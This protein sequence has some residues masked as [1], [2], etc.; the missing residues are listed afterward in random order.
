MSLD[1]SVIRNLSYL[2]QRRV[3]DP[4]SRE[5]VS[6]ILALMRPR[7]TSD[8]SFEL[9][10]PGMVE[11]G[12]VLTADQISDVRQHLGGGPLFE[13]YRRDLGDFR[14]GSVPVGAHLGQYQRSCVIRAPHLLRLANSPQVL[15][16]ATGLIGCKPTLSD[17]LVWW[18]FP[19][20]QKAVD[21]QLWHRDRADWRMAK[22]FV[23]LTDVNERSG[24]HVYAKETAF[25][26]RLTELRRFSASEVNELHPKII[27]IMGSAGSAV[28]T[29]P[30]GLHR[31]SLPIENPRLLF[32]AT[33]SLCGLPANNY[34]PHGYEPLQSDQLPDGLDPWINRFWMKS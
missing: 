32:E 30:Q 3:M 33:Y 5:G 20:P 26:D 2:L 17:M 23:Y 12:T 13:P 1:N 7:G 22:L 34:L 25:V 29:N 14:L 4:R 10:S 27:E 19:G 11:L 16:Y 18:S 9:I 15:E 6:R 8:A 28:M 21:S 31:A 24:P